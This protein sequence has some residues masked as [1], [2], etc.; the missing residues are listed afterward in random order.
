MQ[1]VQM[2][3]HDN[4]FCTDLYDEHDTKRSRYPESIICAGNLN[5]DDSECIGD[6]G[7]PLTLPMYDNGK[8]PFYQI[9]VISFGIKCESKNDP[10]GFTSTQHFADWILRMV[11]RKAPG[12]K[13]QMI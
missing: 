3:L 8:F 6:L 1:Q 5:G 4:Q 2:P 10:H 11:N 7:G 12:A 9:G 13:H